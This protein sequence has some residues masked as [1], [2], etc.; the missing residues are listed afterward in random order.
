MVGGREPEPVEAVAAQR[1]QVGQLADRGEGHAAD[2][3]DGHHALEA[4]QVETDLSRRKALYVDFQQLAQTDLPRIPLIT[5]GQPLL[6]TR[7][8]SAVPDTAEGIYGNF[9]ELTLA[10]A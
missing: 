4:A 10:A 6:T 7:R 3:L 9:A 8:L 5:N 2:E 1:E